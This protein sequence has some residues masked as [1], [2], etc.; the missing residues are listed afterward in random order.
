MLFPL[1][2]C[3]LSAVLQVYELS[4]LTP[5]YTSGSLWG[6]ILLRGEIFFSAM[7]IA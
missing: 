3:H 1:V 6:S 2:V 5:H 7:L 4:V